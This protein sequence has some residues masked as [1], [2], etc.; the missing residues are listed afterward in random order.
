MQHHHSL[1]LHFIDILTKTQI[2]NHTRIGT[3][4]EINYILNSYNMTCLCL[5]KSKRKIMTCIGT[6]NSCCW[7]NSIVINTAL[8]QGKPFVKWL[9][10]LYLL[11]ATVN[12]PSSFVSSLNNHPTIRMCWFHGTQQIFIPLLSI[13]MLIV[14]LLSNSLKRVKSTFSNV[15]MIYFDNLHFVKKNALFCS[16]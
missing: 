5:V 6:P 15:R 4:C 1:T 2:S 13:E 9:L 14:L 11:I 8:A 3:K 7:L 16:D 10:T 12:T